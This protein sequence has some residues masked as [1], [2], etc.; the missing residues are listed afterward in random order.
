LV[1]VVNPGKRSRVAADKIR[2]LGQDIG[3]KNIVVLGNRVASE[4]DKTLIRESMPDYPILGFLP[5]MDEII[6]ADRDGTRPFDNP[7]NIPEEVVRIARKL[8]ALDGSNA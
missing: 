8:M 2:K 7:D 1:V 6:Q 3:I 4:Q 5:E